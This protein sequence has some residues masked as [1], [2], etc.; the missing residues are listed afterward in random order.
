[1]KKKTITISLTTILVIGLIAFL[2]LR[3]QNANAAQT[4]SDESEDNN[5]N[6]SQANAPQSTGNALADEML[7]ITQKDPMIDT[8]IEY[9]KR[10]GEY[11]AALSIKKNIS[12]VRQGWLGA[13]EFWEKARQAKKNKDAAAYKKYLNYASY[14]ILACNENGSRTFEKAYK[15]LSWHQGDPACITTGYEYGAVWKKLSAEKQDCLKKMYEY[16]IST[17]FIKWQNEVK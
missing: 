6:D 7:G 4:M 3:S 1:M 9:G 8:A 2:L 12:S 14:V 15:H 13:V 17:Q 5:E 16:A 10:I 11:Q